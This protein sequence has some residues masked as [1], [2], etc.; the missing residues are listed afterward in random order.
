MT[1][2]PATEADVPAMRDIYNYEVANG[3]ATFDLEEKSLKE[4]LAWFREIREPHCMIV[5]EAAGEIAGYA[6]LHE[7]RT[8][9]AYRF[10]TESS[11]YIHQD[12]RGK[13]V[14]SLLMQEVIAIARRG[15]FHSIMAGISEDNPASEALHEK[16]GFVRIGREREVG[17]KFERWLD[18]SW[19]QLM[20]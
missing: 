15:G 4:R 1:I 10:T 8:R 12:H 20:L 14:G 17:Y 13:G 9:P 7:F 11:V 16:L 18:V 6:Y 2:R 19:Y 5:A 3:W